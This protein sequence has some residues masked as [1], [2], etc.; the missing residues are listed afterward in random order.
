MRG[1]EIFDDIGIDELRPHCPSNDESL[2]ILCADS[3]RLKLVKLSFFTD[4]G[5]DRPIKLPV[6]LL[7]LRLDGGPDGLLWLMLLLLIAIAL[8]MLV[9]VV[10]DDDDAI[11]VRPVGGFGAK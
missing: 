7:K 1:G 5:P 9:V 4:D 6:L 11:V 10:V 2:R 8:V 3:G